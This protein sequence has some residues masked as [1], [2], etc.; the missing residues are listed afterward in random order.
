VTELNPRLRVR[1]CSVQFHFERPSV[2]VRSPPSWTR[3]FG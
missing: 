3:G 2:D 1:K